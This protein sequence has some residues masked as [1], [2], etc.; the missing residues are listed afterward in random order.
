MVD[1]LSGIFEQM[2]SWVINNLSLQVDPVA[3]SIAAFAL[4]VAIVANRRSA[5][6]L[7]DERDRAGNI[8][9][10][11]IHDHSL[12]AAAESLPGKWKRKSYTTSQRDAGDPE[13]FMCSVY[14]GDTDVEVESVYLKIIFTKGMLGQERWEIRVD[15]Q[16]SEGLA[17]PPAS[18]PFQ[19][20][21]NSRLDWIFPSFVASFPNGRGLE[22]KVGILR[23]MTPSEQLRFEFGAY[24]RVSAAPAVALRQHRLRIFG[25]PT[26][27]GPWTKVVKYPSLFDAL[28]S[29]SCPD[30]LKGWFLEWLECRVDF[31]E[32]LD[33]DKSGE[34]RDGFYQVV[35]WHYW[36]PGSIELGPKH[37]SIGD[38]E[39]NTREHRITRTFFALPDMSPVDGGRTVSGPGGSSEFSQSRIAL[40]MSVLVDSETPR[41]DTSTWPPGVA[42][43]LVLKAAL[44]ARRLGDFK[45][46]RQLTSKEAIALKKH[47]SV[48]SRELSRC[49]YAPPSTCEEMVSKAF[50]GQGEPWPEGSMDE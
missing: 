50:K 20:K 49:T 11:I 23:V 28:A 25:F 15:L 29:S 2:Y 39:H 43:D 8:S 38:P 44:E 10:V 19:M 48:V 5:R 36:P 31:Q 6:M 45:G 27:G 26:R 37:V 22:R 16:A 32:R 47:L 33:T 7:A 24:S 46:R 4:I 14:S 3:S 40:A 17:D 34:L 41:P 21:R 35:L 13:G 1:G 42:K 12:Q 30:S 18:L 9:K